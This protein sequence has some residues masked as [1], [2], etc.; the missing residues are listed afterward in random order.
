MLSCALT[1]PWC[2]PKNLFNVLN[3]NGLQM[4]GNKQNVDAAGTATEVLKVKRSL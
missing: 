3:L 4:K 1:G 2:F